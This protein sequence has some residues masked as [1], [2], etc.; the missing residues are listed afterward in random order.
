MGP[1]LLAAQL[2]QAAASISPLGEKTDKYHCLR[3]AENGVN[4]VLPRVYG[5]MP[6]DIR[7]LRDNYKLERDTIIL[8]SLAYK[9]LFVTASI[10]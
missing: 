4:L 2:K 1:F 8:A 6:S 9:D 3:I 7:V 5:E 10:E